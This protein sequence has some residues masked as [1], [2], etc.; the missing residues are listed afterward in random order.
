[1]ADAN[2]T[3][4]SLPQAPP[5]QAGFE[6]GSQGQMGPPG[7]MPLN[8]QTNNLSQLIT[9]MGPQAQSAG[10]GLEGSCLR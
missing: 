2:P 3:P 4:T 10:M 5:A 9:S 6:N 7:Q 1:M 8:I